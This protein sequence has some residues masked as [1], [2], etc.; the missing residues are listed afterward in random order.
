MIP[1]LKERYDAEIGRALRCTLSETDPRGRTWTTTAT[2]LADNET[3][4]FWV[5]LECHDPAG[6]EPEMAAPPPTT[7]T[8]R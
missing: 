6:S 7:I 5:D 4:S 3:R 8:I 1:W 2:A